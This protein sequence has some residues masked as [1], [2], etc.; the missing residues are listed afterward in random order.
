MIYAPVHLH[1]DDH[2]AGPSLEHA[3]A[4][5]EEVAMEHRYAQV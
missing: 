1:L 3:G 5:V 4:H 2:G